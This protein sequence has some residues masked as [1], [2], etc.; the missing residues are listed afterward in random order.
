MKN[1]ILTECFHSVWQIPKGIK[2]NDE[3]VMDRM[4]TKSLRNK[5]EGQR[6]LYSQWQI[7]KG[8]TSKWWRNE[9]WK[10]FKAYA[11]YGKGQLSQ[12]TNEWRT[13]CFHSSSDPT[14]SEVLILKFL[15]TSLHAGSLELPAWAI[16]F[17]LVCRI[18]SGAV[19]GSQ[20]GLSVACKPDALQLDKQYWNHT[21][22]HKCAVF[23][24]GWWCDFLYIPK[25][26][27]IHMTLVM[28]FGVQALPI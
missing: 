12:R 10:V 6:I 11:Q 19:Q 16:C 4:F 7:T 8:I 28:G 2:S 25:M 9:G 26:H 27:H 23:E 15:T 21:R 5:G 20:Y 3:G 22:L 18:R 1:E 17:A 13:E 14:P 24:S